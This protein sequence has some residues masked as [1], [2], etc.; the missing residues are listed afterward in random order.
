MADVVNTNLKDNGTLEIYVGNALLAEI[1]NGRDDKDFV[2]DVLAGMGYTWLEDG[3]IYSIEQRVLELKG[4]INNLR[5]ELHGAVEFDKALVPEIKKRLFSVLTQLHELAPHD[6]MYYRFC[7]MYG[8]AEA[9]EDGNG[10]NNIIEQSTEEF[11]VGDEISVIAPQE[12][13]ITD[14]CFFDEIEYDCYKLF[15]K[16][17][18]LFGFKIQD[19][20]EAGID[21]YIAKGIQDKVLEFFEEAGIKINYYSE[22]S[23]ESKLND[24]VERSAETGSNEFGKDEFVKE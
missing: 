3:T 8:F 24:A 5:H 19:A 1:E 18:K 4:E 17:C 21:F 15:K 16:Y 2:E 11:Q 20:D 12:V 9:F 13:T 10:S 7:D 22:P 23:L 14:M 6:K